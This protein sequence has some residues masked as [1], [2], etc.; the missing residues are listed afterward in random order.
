M[1]T[2]KV[3]VRLRQRP[4]MVEKSA[5]SRIDGTREKSMFFYFIDYK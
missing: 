4:Q 5:Q 1:Q 2:V 3:L